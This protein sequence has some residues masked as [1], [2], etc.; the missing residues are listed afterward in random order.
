MPL[1]V[2]RFALLLLAGVALCG[3]AQPEPRAAVA[4]AGS[5]ATPRVPTPLTSWDR[6]PAARQPRPILL[7]PTQSLPET[8][9]G[10]RTGTAKL[11]V[12]CGRVEL[13]T[14]GLPPAPAMAVVRWPDGG[15]VQY[16]AAS[17]ERVF[18]WVS[19]RG[20]AIGNRDCPQRAALE[21]TGVR[22]GTAAFRTDRGTA[23][24]TS[25]LL[26][27]PDGR[28]ELA[29]PA[30]DPSQFFAVAPPR[31]PSGRLDYGTVSRDGRSLSVAVQLRAGNACSP[32]ERLGGLRVAE[33]ASAVMVTA[34]VT[35]APNAT[36]PP[37][38]AVCSLALAMRYRAVAVPLAQPLG[39]RVLVDET[40]QQ[41]T[42]CP[43]SAGRVRGC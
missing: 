1:P 25:W 29:Y 26:S 30:V 43:S 4:S 9:T 22:L 15:A 19:A 6:F 20:P 12:L 11:A 27:T 10:F 18:A 37:K 39:A 42:V 14:S 23:R 5:G 3:C 16:P 35:T 41:V 34:R 17:L 31:G 28:D 21:V 36:R 24:M 7:D 33:S 13:P 38:D 8:S 32:E 40:G 2:R